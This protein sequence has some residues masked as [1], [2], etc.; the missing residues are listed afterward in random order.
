VRLQRP[1]FEVGQRPGAE[2]L[3]SLSVAGDDAGGLRTSCLSGR[4]STRSIIIAG[5]TK[6]RCGST[7]GKWIKGSL[8]SNRRKG[9]GVCTKKR[10][11]TC[12][13]GRR[14]R[15]YISLYGTH[16]DYTHDRC[17]LPKAA[18]P[19]PPSYS[20]DSG[21]REFAISHMSVTVRDSGP[22]RTSCMAVSPK[23]AKAADKLGTQRKE[24]V[25]RW[26]FAPQECHPLARIKALSRKI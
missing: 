3:S 12:R 6:D 8:P 5:C 10:I 14:C 25:G 20:S 22:S 11:E 16:L 4:A 9:R 15:R 24:A 26:G 19:R 1:S 21:S 2:S 13:H 23:K 18:R 17:N 7:K